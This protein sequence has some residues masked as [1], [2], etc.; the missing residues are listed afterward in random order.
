MST[1]NDLPME[2]RANDIQRHIINIDTRF[3]DNPDLSTS[4]NFYFTLPTTIRNILRVRLTSLEFPDNFYFWTAAKQNVTI[5][6]IY[7]QPPSTTPI[8]LP[9]TIPDG[10]Y[11]PQSMIAAITAIFTAAGVD[12]IFSVAFDA[13]NGKFTFTSTGVKFAI[14]TTYN[15][16]NR[17]FDYGLGYFIGF[18]YG[19]HKSVQIS[20]SEAEVVSDLTSSFTGNNYLLLCLNDYYCVNHSFWGNTIQ[21]FAKLV[22]K[23]GKDLMEFDDYAGDHIKEIV[24]QGPQDLC[25]FK[26]QL[27]D[28]YGQLVNMVGTNYSFSIEILEIKNINLYNVLRDSLGIRWLNA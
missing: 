4:S 21:A 14:D 24:F 1:I 10:N 22:L 7:C 20:P 6:L 19:L 17:K 8:L 23:A 27:L 28:P 5:R 9:I 16:I 15:S 26:V 3:R 11:T 13:T 2:L 12:T 18:T 25:R